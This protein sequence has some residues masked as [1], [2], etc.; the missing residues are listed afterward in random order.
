MRVAHDRSLSPEELKKQDELAAKD[1]K[2]KG[3]AA[4]GAKGAKGAAA[5]AKKKPAK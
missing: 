1:L 3:G 4:K 2:K 5:A